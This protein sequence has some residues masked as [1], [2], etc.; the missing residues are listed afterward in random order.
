MLPLIYMHMLNGSH[1]E[2]PSGAIELPNELEIFP[3]HHGFTALSSFPLGLPLRGVPPQGG[4][5][6]GQAEHRNAPPRG[7]GWAGLVAGVWL[8][9]FLGF[10]DLGFDFGLDSGFGWISA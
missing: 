7:L 1:S 3:R 10:L 8:P 6:V 5:R 9:W 2:S 4:P